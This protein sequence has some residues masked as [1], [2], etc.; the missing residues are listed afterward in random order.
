MDYIPPQVIA[1]ILAQPGVCAGYVALF[2]L[3]LLGIYGLVDQHLSHLVRLFLSLAEL[4][5]V[6]LVAS[7]EQLA[8]QNPAFG[9]CVSQ[10]RGL[11]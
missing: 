1:F 10:Y 8:Q 9:E 11:H 3:A 6:C 2:T 4:S 5:N 7:Q